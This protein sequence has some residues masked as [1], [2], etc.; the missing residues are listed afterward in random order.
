M[1]WGASLSWLYR[2]YATP[3]DNLT[4]IADIYHLFWAIPDGPKVGWLG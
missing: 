2:I 4:P 1:I 3:P